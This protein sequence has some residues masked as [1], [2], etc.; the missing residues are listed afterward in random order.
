MPGTRGIV[1]PTV[2]GRRTQEVLVVSSWKSRRALA[3]LLCLGSGLAATAV[4]GQET[5]PVFTSES[6]QVRLHVAVFDRK[7]VPVGGLAPDDFEVFEEGVRQQTGF[8]FSSDDSPVDIAIVLDMS[9]S[10]VDSMSAATRAANEFASALDAADCLLF[11]PFATAIAQPVWV[12]G[13]EGV[14]PITRDAVGGDDQTAL[15]DAI[16]TAQV[17][18]RTRRVD[19]AAR[20]AG[21]PVV[22]SC[23]RQGDAQGARRQLLVIVSDGLD[24][25]SRTSW[26]S[27]MDNVLESEVPVISILAGLDH[28]RD[29]RGGS[30]VSWR[31]LSKRRMEDL[32]T[33]SGGIFEH[34][35][36]KSYK[37]LFERLL[38][39]MRATYVVTFPRTS[40]SRASRVTWRQ[41]EVRVPGTD[42]KILA[43]SGYYADGAEA[44]RGRTSQGLAARV[45]ELGGIDLAV[46][47]LRDAMRKA[48]D[49]WSVRLDL[50]QA[51]ELQSASEEALEY[52]LRATWLRPTTGH[53]EAARLAASLGRS[54]LALEQAIRASQAGDDVDELLDGLTS[55]LPAAEFDAVQIR[56]G[57]PR[58]F[59]S[60][61]IPGDVQRYLRVRETDV[62]L[63]RLVS[64]SAALALVRDFS[65]ADFL[66]W[67]DVESDHLARAGRIRGRLRLNLPRH[68]AKAPPRAW[69]GSRDSPFL[70]LRPR[71]LDSMSLEFEDSMTAEEIDALLR[72]ALAELER[73]VKK[74]R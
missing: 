10:M 59:L 31:E 64:D 17:M 72:S 33:G 2:S 66:I 14:R 27:I 12:A 41:V 65:R 53:A 54:G 9:G 44:D 62:M 56:L 49:A 43:P 69:S 63:A 55:D 11:L 47:L 51:L 8:V 13:G 74:R 39:I 21:L 24:S 3:G 18:L 16:L 70:R 68:L 48:P 46:Q 58:V 25:S 42:G 38:Q 52:A 20:R 19:D 32:G 29:F 7:G 61:T 28:D 34:L 60:A 40:E 73:W 4:L 23:G 36:R 1:H 35:A 50:A 5:P 67:F 45:L 37:R 71:T 15:A 30:E 57:A 6:A 22:T 26:G